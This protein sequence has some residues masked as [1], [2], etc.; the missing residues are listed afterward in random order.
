M[1]LLSGLL[2]TK[3]KASVGRA[4]PNC[5]GR[6]FQPRQPFQTINANPMLAQFA[7][8]FRGE[9]SLETR[10]KSLKALQFDAYLPICEAAKATT[11]PMDVEGMRFSKWVESDK[12]LSSKKAPPFW[13]LPIKIPTNSSFFLLFASSHKPTRTIPEEIAHAESAKASLSE[14]TNF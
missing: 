7:G 11:R 3:Q 1:V 10:S 4:V 14:K 13:I 5:L 8:T 9:S 2:C 6:E 12:K